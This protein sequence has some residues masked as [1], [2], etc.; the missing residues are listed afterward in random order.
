[1]AKKKED[2]KVKVIFTEGYEKRYTEA[3][4]K[5]LAAREKKG[6]LNPPEISG[7]PIQKPLER[8]SAR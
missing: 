5:V 6:I 2:I 8:I 1:M 7:Q 3:C 4:L